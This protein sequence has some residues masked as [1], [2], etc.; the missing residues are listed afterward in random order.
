MSLASALPLTNLNLEPLFPGCEGDGDKSTL[1][2]Q[3]VHSAMAEGFQGAVPC[4]VSA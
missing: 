4:G 2:P 3:R 1:L